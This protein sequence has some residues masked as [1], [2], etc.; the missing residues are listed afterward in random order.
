VS[1]RDRPTFLP[2]EDPEPSDPPLLPGL[3][4]N[5]ATPAEPS[6]DRRT[7][8]IAAA[9]LVAILLLGLLAFLRSGGSGPSPA[10]ALPS[11]EY[12][13]VPDPCTVGGPDLPAD[14]RSLKPHRLE[15]LCTWELLRPDRSRSLEVEFRLE[16]TAAS[17]PSGTVA[18]AK[19]FADDLG[20]A[21]DRDRNGGFESGPERV[22]GLG[23]EAF[24]AQASNVV[25]SGPTEKN[26]KSYDMGG[27]LVEVRRRNVV[28]TVRWRGADYPSAARGH[29]KL[30]GRRLT[31]PDARHQAI[32][33]VTAAMGR[34]H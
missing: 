13:A 32:A 30:V 23:D 34:L 16:K 26:A 25:V 3:E 11:V 17:G 10:R 5:S 33:V 1:D 4:G 15:N 24:A 8:V 19:D 12:A 20:Y 6:R 22:D 28:L 18:A 29:K 21:S 14:V 27:A 31:Y 9:S 2:P 7:L